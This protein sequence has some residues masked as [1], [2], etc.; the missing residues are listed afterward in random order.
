MGVQ[1]FICIMT[2]KAFHT[3]TIYLLLLANT[4]THSFNFLLKYGQ[5]RAL[6]KILEKI[7]KSL[8]DRNLL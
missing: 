5:R 1:T 6:A 3:L 7:N 2:H 4:N 8:S